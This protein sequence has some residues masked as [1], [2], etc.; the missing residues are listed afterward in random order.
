MLPL[1]EMEKLLRLDSIWI[2]G[3]SW[4]REEIK[5]SVLK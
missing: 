4:R 3:Y 5:E 2:K 1:R